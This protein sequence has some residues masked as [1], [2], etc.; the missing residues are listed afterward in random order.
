VTAPP[1]PVEKPAKPEPPPKPI[2]L[3]QL[4]QECRIVIEAPATAAAVKA[5]VRAQ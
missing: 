2:T 1:K 4:P 3:D 5:T